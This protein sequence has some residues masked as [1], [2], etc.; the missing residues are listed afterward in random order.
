MTKEEILE[1]VP[2][3]ELDMLIALKVMG[4]EDTG[5]NNSTVWDYRRKIRMIS[6]MGNIRT[7]NP[8]TDIKAAWEVI[9]RMKIRLFSK[10]HTFLDILQEIT[11]KS[12]DLPEGTVINWTDMLFWLTPGNICKAALI[13]TLNLEGKELL[14]YNMQQALLR[15]TH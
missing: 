9:E 6:G 15:R 1:M 14:N 8:S 11:S 5:F 12:V 7:F 3:T 2:G 10:R 4:W 13:A